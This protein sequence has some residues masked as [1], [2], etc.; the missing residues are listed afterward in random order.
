MLQYFSLVF[1][2]V[3]L[4]TWKHLVYISSSSV[5]RC[6]HFFVISIIISLSI[7]NLLIS[8]PFH[9]PFKNVTVVQ[10]HIKFPE[11]GNLL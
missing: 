10:S 8:T 3:W 6:L 1:P 4:V 2:L 9:L 5:Y 11:S 7:S